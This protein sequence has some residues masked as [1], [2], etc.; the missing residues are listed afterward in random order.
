MSQL[1]LVKSL[2]GLRGLA[3][4]YVL[5][6]HIGNYNLKLL[7][8]PLNATGKVGVWIFFGLSAYLLTVKLIWQLSCQPLFQSI[9][10]YFK[11]FYK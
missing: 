9:L 6:S 11:V 2:Q 3:V 1:E 7:P 4:L 10:R 8:I 5:A